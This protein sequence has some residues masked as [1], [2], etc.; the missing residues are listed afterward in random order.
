MRH[1]LCLAVIGVAMI[2]LPAR[3]DDAACVASSER[4]LTLHQ[5]EKLHD[6][7]KELAVCADPRC[8]Q[9]VKAECA[10]RI[11]ELNTVMPTLILTAKDGDGNDLSHVTVSMD[12]AQIAP[13]L[14]GASI[15][16][17]PGEHT[18]RFEAPGQS[19]I[20]KKLVIREGEK[21]RREGVVIGVATVVVPPRA[22][23]WSTQ[24]ALGLV[25]GGL[26]IVGIGL[27]AYFGAFA[28]SAQNQEHA[29]CPA[30]G[31]AHHLQSVADYNTA[32]QDA[33]ASTISFIAGGVFLATGVVL[34]LTAPRLKI[35]PTTTGKNVGFVLGGEF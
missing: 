26:G 3:A 24:R 23:F 22:Q 7:L 9:E 20:E 2:A 29:D 13:V 10:K 15:T 1:A 12:G 30:A 16:I 31:C 27:G 11:D 35:V 28:L 32:G 5:Q 33:V 8:P 17:D 6:A 34:W 14:D 21:E 4:A 19:P 18:F 25:S